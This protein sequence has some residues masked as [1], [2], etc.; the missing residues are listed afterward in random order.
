LT[1]R[2]FRVP[3]SQIGYVRAIIEG[4]DGVAQVFAPDWNRGEIEWR[5]AA[6]QEHEADA[7]AARLAKEAD[8]QDIERPAG[9]RDA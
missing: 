3:V 1:S 6:G 2:F 7:I 4:Y 9:W 8:L 5:I